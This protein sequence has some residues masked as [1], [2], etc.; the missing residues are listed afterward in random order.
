M[1]QDQTVGQGMFFP[2]VNGLLR[3]VIKEG[4]FIFHSQRWVKARRLGERREACLKFDQVQTLTNQSGQWGQIVQLIIYKSENGNLEGLC[5]GLIIGYKE[6][7]IRE[8]YLS[9]MRE[10]GSLQ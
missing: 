6:S 8:F 10:N 4:F 1:W 9:H 7:V 5:L 2:E 3:G